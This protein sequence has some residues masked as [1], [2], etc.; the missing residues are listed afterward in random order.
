[1]IS[2]SWDITSTESGL[3]IPPQDQGLWVA[4]TKVLLK[5]ADVS[6]LPL[7]KALFHCKD[8]SWDDFTSGRQCSWNFFGQWL[9]KLREFYLKVKMRDIF[10][11]HSYKISHLTHSVNCFSV[12]KSVRY[13]HLRSHSFPPEFSA[14]DSKCASLPAINSE[15]VVTCNTINCRWS[16][17]KQH[18]IP[19]FVNLFY[20][21]EN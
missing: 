3:C 5:K 14:S 11:A 19:W 21:W 8:G 15:K 13:L 18:F 2:N 7:L 4:Q 1:M 16:N 9:S 20:L 10:C 6:T 17:G 12:E